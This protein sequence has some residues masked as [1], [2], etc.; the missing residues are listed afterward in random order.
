MVAS[1]AGLKY[2]MISRIAIAWLITLPV[3]I[4]IAGGLY[5]L[6]ANPQL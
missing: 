4:S 6:L 1:G 5:Y 2:G 3:T